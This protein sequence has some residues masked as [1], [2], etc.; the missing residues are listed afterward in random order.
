LPAMG[1][2]DRLIADL[3][4]PY[5]GAVQAW[6]VQFKYGEVWQNEHKLGDMVPRGIYRRRRAAKPI[7]GGIRVSGAAEEPC[8][9]C[10]AEEIYA[11]ITVEDERMTAVELFCYIPKEH[12][13]TIILE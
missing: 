2:F 10:G 7:P 3:P 12:D 4:C 13:D 6:R 9:K 8:S 1:A 11:A 5:C